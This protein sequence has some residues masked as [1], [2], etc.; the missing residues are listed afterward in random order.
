[1][2]STT[3]YNKDLHG[4]VEHAFE[5]SVIDGAVTWNLNAHAPR[6]NVVEY[7]H[8]IDSSGDPIEPTAGSVTITM[9]SG[10]AVYQT[11][12]EGSFLAVDATS[13]S[14]TKPN[15]FGKADN[16]KVTLSGVTGTGVVGFAT[17]VTQSES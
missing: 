2:G 13:P 17:F 4:S 16:I 1:M 3:W 14:R 9:S 7:F 6:N 11:I 15:G 12:S 5:S 8:F 10:S